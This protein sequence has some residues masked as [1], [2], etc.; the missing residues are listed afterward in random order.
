MFLC[1]ILMIRVC[2][3]SAGRHLQDDARHQGRH[4]GGQ[5]VPRFCTPATRKQRAFPPHA[6][7]LR[8]QALRRRSHGEFY[9][10]TMCASVQWLLKMPRLVP[11]AAAIV[12]QKCRI[13]T[14]Y[15]GDWYLSLLSN[16]CLRVLTTFSNMKNYGSPQYDAGK[17]G[18]SNKDAL[19]NDLLGIIKSSSDKLL[20]H[21][22]RRLEQD[23]EDGGTAQVCDCTPFFCPALWS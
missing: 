15:H 4:G 10:G 17:L 14:F 22:F 13:R 1:V 9:F 3:Y 18:E 23:P 12:R 6:Q 20:Q 8:D 19:D 16:L 5:K 21:L 11:F 2:I 7:L